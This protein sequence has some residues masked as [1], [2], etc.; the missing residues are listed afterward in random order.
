MSV[1]END[2][3]PPVTVA[4]TIK[5]YTKK[6]V[7]AHLHNKGEEHWLPRS[8]IEIEEEDGDDVIIHIRAWLAEKTHIEDD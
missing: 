8:Q 1:F 7:L 5:V 6:A 4:A 3:R 2:Q